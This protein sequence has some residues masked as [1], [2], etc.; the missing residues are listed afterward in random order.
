VLHGLSR[1]RGSGVVGCSSRQFRFQFLCQMCQDTGLRFG[2]QRDL[3]PRQGKEI[4]PMRGRLWIYGTAA[5]PPGTR[6]GPFEIGV[7]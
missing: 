7:Q 5:M 6:N 3:T 1:H 4:G 2:G